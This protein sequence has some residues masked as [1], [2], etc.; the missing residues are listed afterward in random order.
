M[1]VDFQTSL[2]DAAASEVATERRVLSAGA[3]VDVA[4]DWLPD[5][6]DV[7]ATLVREVPWRAER[8]A[9]YDRVVDVPRLVFTYMIGDPLPHPA[10]S[11]A[12]ERLSQRYADEL[13][14]PFRTAGCCYYRDGRDSVAW[15]GD[16]IGRGSTDDTMVAIVSVGDPR[17]LHLRPR[18]PERRDEAF[19]VEMGHGDLVV[20][21]GSCQ[22]T[23]EHAVPKVASA[24]PRISVQ[25]RPLNVF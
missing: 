24:G 20:M 25:F 10:L 2:F 3:W 13:G 23:W 18:D 12:R 9:M 14:E 5:A 6:D 7:F 15:H 16:T 22:R 4:R 1:T 21:G 17:R 19:A 8:R 11:D